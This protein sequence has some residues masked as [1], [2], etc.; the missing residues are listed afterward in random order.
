MTNELHR[1][2]S[3]HVAAG[4][5]NVGGPVDEDTLHQAEAIVGRFPTDYRAFVAEFGWLEAPELTV[6]G[7]GI[8]MSGHLDVVHEALSERHDVAP[9]F[10]EEYIAI[11]PDGAGNVHCVETGSASP[12]Y[13][14]DHESGKLEREAA[15]FT[16]F[17]L[18]R[19]ALPER[20]DEEPIGELRRL[21]AQ[22]VAEGSVTVGS[23]VGAAAIAEAESAVGPFPNDYRA[24]VAEFGWLEARGQF[25][26]YGLGRDVPDGL[27]VVHETLRERT[28]PVPPLPSAFIA[29]APDR[30]GNVYCLRPG[31][32]P[33][34][35]QDR[36][37]HR[38]DAHVTPYA[39][40]FA[41]FL[42][43]RLEFWL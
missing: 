26:A 16:S 7:L 14:H 39:D 22:R 15:D 41:S 13:L 32:P 27:D 38:E 34:H 4:R 19:L 42:G 18:D 43:E 36:E 33:V 28:E 25:V 24:F 2:I 21:V 37:F 3:E 12:V 23:P 30:R 10:P 31:E 40:D 5:A 1:L 29:I 6:F 9:A 35:F 20:A 8:G 11:A 17:V